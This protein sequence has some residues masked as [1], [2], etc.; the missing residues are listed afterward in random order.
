MDDP[1]PLETDELLIVHEL[2]V[3]N[4]RNQIWIKSNNKNEIPPVIEFIAIKLLI[5]S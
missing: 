1:V 5:S 2:G 3:M 4:N